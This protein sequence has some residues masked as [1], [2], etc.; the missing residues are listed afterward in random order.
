MAEKE[1]LTEILEKFNTDDCQIT[2]KCGYCE[3]GDLTVCPSAVAEHLLSNGVIVPPCKVGDTLW[4]QWSLTKAH[5][6]EIYPVKVYALRYDTK[7]RSK[8][9]CVEGQFKLHAYGGWYNHYYN[10]TFSWDSIGKT[11]FLT[12]E[13]AEKAL[14]E[15]GKALC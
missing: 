11:V 7:E 8:R 15:R 5:K 4:V 10:A 14:A 2:H 13:E 12:K 3:F 1:R 6:K 9:I